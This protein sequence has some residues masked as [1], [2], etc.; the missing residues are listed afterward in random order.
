MMSNSTDNNVDAL[1][2][3]AN[4][5]YPI[6]PLSNDRI[7]LVLFDVSSVLFTSSTASVPVSQTPDGN[8]LS[9]T[10]PLFYL[11]GN[12]SAPILDPL[13]PPPGA[14]RTHDLRPIF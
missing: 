13:L 12:A 2:K 9:K 1:A 3:A 14:L 4:F 6:R 10:I 7:S 5:C 8:R 11:A